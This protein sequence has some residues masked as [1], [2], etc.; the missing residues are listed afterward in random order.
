VFATVWLAKMALERAVRWPLYFIFFFC[1]LTCFAVLMHVLGNDILI[2]LPQNVKFLHIAQL[3]EVAKG[4]SILQEVLEANTERTRILREANLLQSFSSVSSAS[5]AGFNKA[6]H[7][8]LVA[9]SKAALELSQKIA[10]KRSGQRGHTARQALLVA[11][12]EYEE[13]LCAD[14]DTHVTP[15]RANEVMKEV[16]SAYEGID[17]DG[18]IARAKSILSGLGF[19]EDE[20]DKEG[21]EVGA[22]SGGW[23]MRVM[24]A[25]ALFVSPDILLLDEPS[26]SSPFLLNF[27]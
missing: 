17:V 13:V 27:V 6:I 18:D 12:S 14:P 1:V 5:D 22:L 21:K 16:F 26:T 20:M 11:E 24:L 4:R 9:R 25:K 8:I 10:A 2:G 3:E 15:Q 7:E 23:R 19:L